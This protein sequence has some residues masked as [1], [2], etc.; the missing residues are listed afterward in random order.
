[1]TLKIFSPVICGLLF[2]TSCN[3]SQQPSDTKVTNGKLESGF[4][5]VV[6]ISLD[7]SGMCTGTFVSDSLL[8]TAAH[9]VDR[10]STISYQG[11]SVGRTDVF[12]NPGWPTTADACEAVQRDPKYDIA[13]VRFPAGTFRGTEFA[14]LLGRTPV[15]DEEF[16][17]VGFGNTVI[18]PFEKF[19]ML[20]GKADSNN[21]C[22][23]LAGVKAQGSQYNYSKV[24]SFAAARQDT[25]LGCPIDCPVSALRSAIIDQ[26]NDLNT[27]LTKNCDGNFRDRSYQET[28]AGSKRSGKN[29][30]KRVNEGLV[31]FDGHTGGVDSGLDSASGAGDSGGPM[32]VYINGQAKL[33]ATTHGGYLSGTEGKLRKNSFYVDLSSEFNLPWIRKIVAEQNLTFPEINPQQ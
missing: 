18:K 17:I 1:M 13:L 32:F 4:P 21:M 10:F 20:P 23:L 33:A 28:G 7:S 19:C 9:C 16:T 31:E 14:K 29:H 8:I 12:I 26:G 24:I 5:Y 30:V 22:H 6:P 11:T 25:S 27:F 3:A 15:V 2:L